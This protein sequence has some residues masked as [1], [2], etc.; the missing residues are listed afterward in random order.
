GGRPRWP[1][2][3]TGARGSVPDPPGGAGLPQLLEALLVAQRVH[4][5]PEPLVPVGHE[6]PVLGQLLERLA[7]ELG[8]VA[9]DVV[10]HARLQHEEGAV[11][12]AL[13]RLGLLVELDDLVA[14][15]LE[16]TEAGGGPG[17]RQGGE[18][19]VRAVELDE[20][21]EVDRRHAVAPGDHERAV[22]QVGLEALD[23]A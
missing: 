7:L 4:A 17:G 10:E 6:L 23:A 22:T 14:V 20:L 18:L 13:A 16:V 12:P 15:E 11:D 8:V 1:R 3:A 9:G 2:S 19:A 21:V 5:L